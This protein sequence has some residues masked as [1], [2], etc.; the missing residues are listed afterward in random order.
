MPHFYNK[1]FAVART[2]VLIIFVPFYWGTC[3]RHEIRVSQTVQN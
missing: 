3:Q 2:G 1:H